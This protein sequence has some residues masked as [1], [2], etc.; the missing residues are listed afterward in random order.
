MFVDY[1]VMIK[2]VKVEYFVY[3]DLIVFIMVSNCFDVE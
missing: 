1:G 2:D 3:G